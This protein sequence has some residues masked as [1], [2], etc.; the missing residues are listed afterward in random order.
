MYEEYKKYGFPD[1]TI[2]V[3]SLYDDLSN[4]LIVKIRN[5]V[6]GIPVHSFWVRTLDG[7]KYRQLTPKSSNKLMSYD[8]EC[9]TTVG[10]LL[11]ICEYTLE[12]HDTGCG[13]NFSRI[14]VY[15]LSRN[16]DLERVLTKFT[17]D[18]KD[19]DAPETIS[20]ISPTNEKNHIIIKCSFPDVHGSDIY[21][22]CR[23]NGMT[24]EIRPLMRLET[25]HI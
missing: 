18:G 22:V 14:Y 4:T 16:L 10:S 15:N 19:Y 25:I 6:K 3:S 7:R 23:L 12:I 9:L 8:G 1:K 13:I 20:I 2:F 5:D 21:W 24:G 17:V 11:Y